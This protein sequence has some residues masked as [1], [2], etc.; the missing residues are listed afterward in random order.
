MSNV[1]RNFQ[2][3]VAEFVQVSN[4][5]EEKTKA[6]L[7]RIIRSD[8]YFQFMQDSLTGPKRKRINYYDITN[9]LTD[10]EVSL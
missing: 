4:L 8:D 3:Q 2:E 9:D 6:D 7:V 5:P 1:L 10:K